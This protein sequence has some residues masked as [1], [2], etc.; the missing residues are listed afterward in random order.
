MD[1]HEHE[2]LPAAYTS[3]LIDSSESPLVIYGLSPPTLTPKVP[4][5]NDTIQYPTPGPQDLPHEIFP[6][7]S[8][9]ATSLCRSNRLSITSSK[10]FGY[11][12]FLPGKRQDNISYIGA[13]E[14][15]NSSTNNLQSSL[16]SL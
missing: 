4:N 16:S 7:Q 12:F 15:T 10:L 14:S 1:F 6:D 11:E 5:S 8:S 13:L 2:H 3:S 9:D